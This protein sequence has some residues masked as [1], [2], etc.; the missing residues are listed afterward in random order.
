MCYRNPFC[1]TEFFPYCR[2]STEANF[3]VQNAFLSTDL[4]QNLVSSTDF[5]SSCEFITQLSSAIQSSICSTGAVQ[6]SARSED[7]GP[8]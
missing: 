8:R 2:G 7:S 3:E 1:S 6:N 4:V 5:L